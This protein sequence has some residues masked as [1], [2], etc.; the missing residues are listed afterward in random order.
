VPIDSGLAH[1]SDT[2]LFVAVICYA[3]AFVGYAAEFA[4]G[5]KPAVGTTLPPIAGGSVDTLPE[6]WTPATSS[7][8]AGPTRS[9]RRRGS[10]NRGPGVAFGRFAVAM[11]LVGW[12]VHNAS[13]VTRGLAAHR[14]PWGNMYE[15]SS[16]VCLI[17]VTSFL[18]LLQRQRVRYLG[19]FV[20]L[21]VVLYLG[22]AGTVLYAEA[23][24]LLPALHSYWIK[25]HVVAAMSSSGIF[26]VGF[27]ATTLF[28]VKD[29]WERRHATAD[30]GPSSGSLMTRLPRAATLDRVAH[31]VIAFAFPIWTFAVIA[32]AIWA[33]AAWGRY[34]GWDPKE[35]WSFITWVVYAG[36]LHARATAGW[37]GRRAAY[38]AIAGFVSLMICYYAVNLWI[39]GLHSY[40]GV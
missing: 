31:R 2:L 23:A 20:M 28:L 24:P 30:G 6:D 15:F 10:P 18:V 3:V 14:V 12:A 32:G 22:L 19:A 9:E 34:W 21:P 35:T 8:L 37:K 1:T 36:Y 38:V 11:T 7:T 27:V 33:E 16:M 25:I 26:M 5:R 17:A 40:A 39:S 4:F 13:V 29:A